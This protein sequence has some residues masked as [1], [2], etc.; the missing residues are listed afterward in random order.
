[1]GF[2]QWPLPSPKVLL[3]ILKAEWGEVRTD[4]LAYPPLALGSV[5]ATGEAEPVPVVFSSNPPAGDNVSAC[6][7]FATPRFL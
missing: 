4:S 7:L 1:M 3:Q 2:W 6:C 5:L